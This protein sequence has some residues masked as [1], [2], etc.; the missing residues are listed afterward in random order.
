MKEFD[1]E[2]NICAKGNPSL[3]HVLVMTFPLTGLISDLG[4]CMEIVKVLVSF[5]DVIDKL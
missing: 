4:V 5:F 2:E 3:P 1:V